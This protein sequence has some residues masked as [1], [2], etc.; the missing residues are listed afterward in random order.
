MT[1][2]QLIMQDLENIRD[3]LELDE[4]P[5]ISV[6]L[7]TMTIDLIN[8][9]KVEIKRL[10]KENITLPKRFYKEG[11][12]DFAEQL[13]EYNNENYFAYDAEFHN[14]IVDELLE[15]MIGGE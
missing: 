11:A 13:K 1:E 9:Q 6:E 3:L 15:K 12:K 10:K 5:S 2:E 8:R 4:E 7:I 14:D